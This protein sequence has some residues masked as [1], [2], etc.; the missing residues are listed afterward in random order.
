VALAATELVSLVAMSVLAAVLVAVLETSEVIA[1][2]AAVVVPDARELMS[3]VPVVV[4]TSAVVADV[5]VREADEETGTGVVI[6]EATTVVEVGSVEAAVESMAEEA[7][8]AV[9]PLTIVDTVD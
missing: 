1:T 7:G 8:A 9:V 2:D 3:A 6:T 4:E 5:S